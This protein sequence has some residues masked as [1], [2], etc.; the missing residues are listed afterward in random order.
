[1]E[2]PP[3]PTLP[4]K[5]GGGKGETPTTQDE[6][7]TTKDERPPS[8]QDIFL[9]AFADAHRREYG[10]AI[11]DRAVEVVNCR[12]KAVGLIDRPPPGF[13][14]TT[15]TIEPKSRRLVHFDTGWTDTPIHDRADLGPTTR[16]PG[17]A[18]IDEMSA[19]T[20]IPAGWTVTVDAAGNLILET[21]P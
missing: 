21:T 18:V 19:T 16:L 11:P 13:T 5:G 17:P 12:L 1:V 10:Y 15:G 4:L 8:P 6:T 9:S 3:T 7:P 2:L 14:A 20:L